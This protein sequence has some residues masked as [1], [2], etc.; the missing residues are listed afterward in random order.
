MYN[1]DS[2]LSENCDIQ[3]RDN[4][5]LALIHR[6][7]KTVSVKRGISRQIFA[8]HFPALGL[9]NIAHYLRINFKPTDNRKLSIKY[10]DE[11]EYSSDEDFYFDI[12]SWL[13]LFDIKILGASTYT[14]TID[15]IERFLQRFE[16]NKYLTI[17]GGAH[18]TLAP[19]VESGHFIIRGEGGR[20]IKY[21]IENLFKDSFFSDINDKG[22]CF[23]VNTVVSISKQSYDKSI[24][25]LQSPLFA[26]D[27][28]SSNQNIY[29]TNFTRL[30]G[31]NP[32]IYVCT[33]SCQ[34][35]CSFCSTYLIHGKQVARSSILIKED[36]NYLVKI[37]GYDCIEFHDDDLLQHP[38]FEKI[39]IILKELNIKWFC[40]CR[41]DLINEQIVSKMAHSG[42]K[43]V[44]IGIE[45]FRQEKLDYFNKK[46]TVAQNI[47]AIKTFS[48]HSV[49]VV[50]GFIIGN[51]DD[52]IESIL[53]ELD[54]F[55]SLGLYAI[56]CSILSPDPGTVEFHRARKKNEEFKSVFGGDNNNRLIPNPQLYGIEAPMGLPV[57]SREISK[58][59]L[60]F[61]LELI[62]SEFYLRIS[63]WEAL[64]KDKLES[65]KRLINNYY[66]FVFSRLKNICNICTNQKI[67]DRALI[68]LESIVK[69]NFLEINN[70]I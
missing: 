67:Q 18:V 30:I 5:G 53:N 42:C 2:Y 64:I 56:N 68:K 41:A 60:N 37:K 13:E 62:D 66:K 1:L 38:E 7:F 6:S 17:L 54:V 45:S 50:A 23:S 34:A 35:R 70:I 39:L 58:K 32:Q 48:N 24:E 20:A 31:Q 8:A 14:S 27:L 22:I 61:L 69:N 59:D 63:I 11:G 47:K 49:G 28:L 4:Y 12:K 55:L 33:Q 40:Y 44:F 21:I 16:R 15:Y 51:P 10:F 19:E 29:C 46:T 52:T 26:Y 57:L 3:S 25:E 43:R 65:E 36:L 9:L